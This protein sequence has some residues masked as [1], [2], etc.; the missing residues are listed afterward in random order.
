[1]ENTLYQIYQREAAAFRWFADLD[2]EA[3][4][5][6]LLYTWYTM[7]WNP[8]D[9]ELSLQ[10]FYGHRIDGPNTV[11][12]V[13]LLKRRHDYCETYAWAIPNPEAIATLVQHSPLIEIGAGRGYWAALAAAEGADILA[14]D[15]NLPNREG[16]N[17]WHR[18]PEIG[19]AHV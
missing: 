15:P 11:R 1:M 5:S 7:L 3:L 12:F 14:F 13:Q 8:V 17:T 4:R 9:F 18:Q 6:L 19:R 10:K 16:A 2:D